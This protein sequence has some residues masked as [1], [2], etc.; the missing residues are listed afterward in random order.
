M[1][2]RSPFP[3]ARTDPNRFVPVLDANG[4]QIVVGGVPQYRYV[5]AG[6]GRDGT[7]Y[8]SRKAFSPKQTFQIGVAYDIALGS[9]GT[10]TPEVQTYYNSG[11]ILTDLTPDYGKNAAYFKTDLRLTYRTL[12]GKF[13]IQ[14]FVNNLEN[15]AI[16]TRAVYTNHRALLVNYAPARSY[17]LN[18]S[19]R[20]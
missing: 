12:D 6:T 14:A 19:F 15:Q 13:S 3:N 8:T 18:A 2:F 1:L 5:I 11:Y 10:L 17:G 16:I 7:K 20:F 4:A 9:A